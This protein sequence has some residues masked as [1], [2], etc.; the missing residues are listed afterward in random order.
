MENKILY[1]IP[2]TW[3][4][5]LF[6]ILLSGNL[7]FAQE[8]KQ[9]QKE[10]KQTTQ[11]EY[12]ITDYLRHENFIYNP[13]IK[14]VMLHLEENELS[15]PVMKLNSNNVLKLSFDI[16]DL[17]LKNYMYAF[18]HCDA[19]WA[20]SALH[21]AEYLDGFFENYITDYQFSFN[22][23][24]R[25]MHYN[26][27]FPNDNINF[28]ASGNYLLVVY[29]EGNR[30]KP[31]ITR[32]FMVYEEKVIVNPNVVRAADPM[33]RSLKQK[34][35]FSILH[36]GYNILNPMQDLRVAVLQNNRWDNANTTLKPLFI[37]E[38]ELV[39][40]YDSENLFYGGNEFR[41]F[42]IKTIRFKTENVRDITYEDGKN[43]VFL[44][45]DRVLSTNRYSTLP[46]IN[47][48]YVIRIQEGWD[49]DLEADYAYVHFNLKYPTPLVDGN[50]YIFGAISDWNFHN[51]YKL[52]YDPESLS[53]HTTLYLKQGYYNY[54]Y[55]FLEDGTNT[56]NS[57]LI[58]GSYFETENDYSIFVYHREPST[59]YH[60]II[61]YRQFNSR[62][63]F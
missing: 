22:T 33:E 46:D 30:D 14:T 49:S 12:Y 15:A 41:N 63:P 39:Y 7:L 53:Y 50:L 52:K 28:T 60:K 62:G 19:D 4:L 57:Y 24:E 40:N 43:N 31:V 18:I 16:L 38:S 27:F 10:E 55:S 9:K 3:L 5:L 13:L 21:E 61:G 37:K 29:E 2:K 56:G 20:P 8:K 23:L 44:K 59:N 17:E 45:E 11:E 54:S 48:K 32:R 25:Y 35:D 6:V 36:N 42:D 47:G 51:D 26:L 58:D 34:I 1:T